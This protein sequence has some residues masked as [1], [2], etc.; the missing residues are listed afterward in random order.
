MLIAQALGEY[1]V[2][3]A[4]TESVTGAFIYFEETLNGNEPAALIAA[5][6]AIWLVIRAIR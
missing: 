4:M 2:A 1:G 3:A 5:A 6:I